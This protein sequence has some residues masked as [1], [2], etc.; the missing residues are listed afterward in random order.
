MN[1]KIDT[2]E[3]FLQMFAHFNIKVNKVFHKY[4]LSGNYKYCL[5]IANITYGNK[6]GYIVTPFTNYNLY[7]PKTSYL[8]KSELHLLF[9]KSLNMILY[10]S[11]KQHMIKHYDTICMRCN[12]NIL[13]DIYK[14]E[15]CDEPYILCDACCDSNA[16]EHN[17]YEIINKEI[18]P[19]IQIFNDE[20]IKTE[21]INQYYG[22]QCLNLF[23][24]LKNL[25]LKQE[26]FNELL[27][28]FNSE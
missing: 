26:I 6:T 8:D 17:V 13:D 14:C 10:K 21:M 1:Q 23:P 4:F 11:N 16:H 15:I 18:N 9:I 12:I 19:S 5:F 22:I 28:F 25:N 7:V 24:V 2:H 3:Y 27:H 20:Q